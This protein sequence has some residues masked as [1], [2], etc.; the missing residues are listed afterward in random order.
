MRREAAVQGPFCAQ[1]RIEVAIVPIRGMHPRWLKLPMR[2]CSA[3][4]RQ[5]AAL[6]VFKRLLINC[7]VIVR[8]ERVHFCPPKSR[9]VDT[10]ASRE[11]P[12]R[13]YRFGDITGSS[14]PNALKS[15]RW[16]PIPVNVGDRRL[17]ESQ[18]CPEAQIVAPLEFHEPE[19]YRAHGP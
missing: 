16:Q 11:R 7:G 18:N 13:G 6:A 14:W 17:W 12:L 4:S 1:P 5:H 15:L 2:L 19:H 3:L 9:R 10:T 8:Y